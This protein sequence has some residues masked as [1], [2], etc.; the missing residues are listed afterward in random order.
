MPWKESCTEKLGIRPGVPNPLGSITAGH[1]YRSTEV[2]IQILFTSLLC[3][4]E[5]YDMLIGKKKKKKG[6]NKSTQ[7]LTGLV[8]DILII[9]LVTLYGGSGVPLLY[10][11]GTS[12]DTSTA[13]WQAGGA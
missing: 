10:W 13:A 11:R 9:L 5:R 2:I 8:L 1:I 12:D 3:E 6:E 7:T 4:E